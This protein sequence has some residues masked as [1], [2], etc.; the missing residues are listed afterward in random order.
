M[1]ATQP[2]TIC[3]FSA[4]CAT[5]LHVC[6]KRL[7][8][9]LP[10]KPFRR[11]FLFLSYMK[12]VYGHLGSSGVCAGVVCSS[13]YIIL[14]DDASKSVN[15]NVIQY[16]TK[17]LSFMKVK[18]DHNITGTD[19]T[20]H[21]TGI[22]AKTHALFALMLTMY[23]SSMYY[24]KSDCD[25]HILNEYNL[26]KA[27]MQSH[28]HYWGSCE[29]SHLMWKSRPA[30][31]RDHRKVEYPYAQG[32]LYALNKTS[33]KLLVD[34]YVLTKT[35][36]H[37]HA[38]DAAVGC[39]MHMAHIKLFCAGKHINSWGD[40]NSSADVVHPNKQRKANC[41]KILYSPF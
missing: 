32:G 37:R 10:F 11:F 1:F 25:T 17:H 27:I 12:F 22:V 35:K 4:A 41:T 39:A 26:H 29:N 18:P 20:M 6:I 2:D 9:Y 21:K 15:P 30:Y 24:I 8:K 36:C 28:S 31:I 34:N 40:Y 5:L 7:K 19:T 38:E 16:N 14:A 13:T 23:P 33:A 3:G